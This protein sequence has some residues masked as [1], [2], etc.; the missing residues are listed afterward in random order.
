LKESTKH[1]GWAPEEIRAHIKG[2][3]HQTLQEALEV[4]FA[5]FLGC[6][7]HT[8]SPSENMC[9]EHSRRPFTLALASL[10]EVHPNMVAQCERQAIEGMPE[11]F[12]SKS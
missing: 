12:K 2:L 6:P 7:K 11:S 3:V 8:I 10:F 9:N 4:E 1:R 5:D